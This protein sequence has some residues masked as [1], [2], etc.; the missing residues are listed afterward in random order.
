MC[1]KLPSN[2]SFYRIFD[3]IC[4]FENTYG[5]NMCYDIPIKLVVFFI[6]FFLFL[7]LFMELLSYKMH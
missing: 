4:V 6:I 1:K 7:L 5:A 3:F 2:L